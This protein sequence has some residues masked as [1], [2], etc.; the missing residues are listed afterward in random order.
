[1][2][3]FLEQDHRPLFFQ[4]AVEIKIFTNGNGREA[5]HVFENLCAHKEPLVTISKA[6]IS[7]ADIR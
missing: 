6:K 2:R 3:L 1:M 4:A 5:I 7:G